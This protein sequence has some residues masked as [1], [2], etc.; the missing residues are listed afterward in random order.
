[1]HKQS[2]TIRQLFTELRSEAVEGEQKEIM[3][4]S[5]FMDKI[6]SIGLTPTDEAKTAMKQ[7][8]TKKGK[9]YSFI[10]LQDLVNI[11]ETFGVKESAPQACSNRESLG[12]KKPKKPMNY[13]DLSPES[14]RIMGVFT[15]FLLDSDTSVY[16]FFDGF[17]YN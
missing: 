1:M 13:S 11:M 10:V 5:H 3:E 14:L 7:V 8:L 16:E 9:L 6:K 4:V 2:L 15:D 12:K 17:V